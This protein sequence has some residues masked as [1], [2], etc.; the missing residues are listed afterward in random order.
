MM[1]SKRGDRVVP[2]GPL[3]DEKRQQK[4]RGQLGSREVSGRRLEQWQYEVTS[5]RIWYCPDLD[6]RITWVVVASTAHLKP[7]E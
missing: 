1:A 2:P 6:K 4:L 7:T 5:G 3:V